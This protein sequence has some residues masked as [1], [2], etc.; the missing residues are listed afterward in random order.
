MSHL[1]PIAITTYSRID[2]LKKTVESLQKNTLA[3]ASEL[4]ILLDGPRRGD[5]ELVD[6]VRQYIYTMDGFKGVHINERETNDRVKNYRDGVSY[7]LEKYGKI[8]FMEDDN[9]TSPYFLQYMNDGLDFYKDNKK[10]M[11]II[12]YNIPAKFPK[13]YRYDYYLSKY[14]NAWGFATWPD[15][16]HLEIEAYN[17]AYNEMM[18]DEKLYKKVKRVHPK[19]INGLKRV[20]EGTL[21]AGDYRLVF[22]LIKNDLYTIKPIKSLVKNIGHDGSGIHCG[23]SD[24]FNAEPYNERINIIDSELPKYDENYDKQ[25]YLYF[26]PKFHLLNRL[27]NK[28]K[29]I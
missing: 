4:Y 19:L 22:H 24:R 21:N 18:K 9:V 27:K 15:R 8:I 23:I 5:E 3:K 29:K 6:I 10:I 12:G 16:K 17:D 1:A 25:Y 28:L 26:N 11:A 7:L 2:H 14:F 20:Q 13:D